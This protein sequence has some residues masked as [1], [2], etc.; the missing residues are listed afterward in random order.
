MGYMRE[1]RTYKGLLCQE[2]GSSAAD[3]DG[4]GV[5]DSADIRTF[6]NVILAAAP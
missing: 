4:G 3:K 6:K 2:S 1:D 5:M